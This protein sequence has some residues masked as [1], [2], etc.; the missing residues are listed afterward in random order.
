MDHYDSLGGN[1]KGY[2]VVA[3]DDKRIK[4]SVEL[5]EA[6]FT[7]KQIKQAYGIL[8]DPRYKSGDLT[9]AVR[10]IEKLAKGLS[11]HPGVQKA[12]KATSEQVDLE[13]SVIDVCSKINGRAMMR[14]DAEDVVAKLT[15]ADMK[16]IARN[17]AQFLKTCKH[18]EKD[19]IFSMVSEIQG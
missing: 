18:K 6:K 8:N 2:K 13:E 11:K 7:D 19:V 10:A 16:D 5:E 15:P 12:M 1:A 4:E 17:K 3:T 14:M 9:H